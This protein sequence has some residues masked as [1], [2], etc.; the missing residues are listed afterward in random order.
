[1]AEGSTGE[2]HGVVAEVTETRVR[3]YPLNS[4]RLTARVVNRIACSLGLPKSPLADARLMIEGELAKT[5]EP[6][7]VQVD[8]D[9]SEPEETATIRLRDEGGIYLQIEASTP[10]EKLLQ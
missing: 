1:M 8:V 4:R 6:Q 10:E 7:N 2:K 3:T 5:C 9:T